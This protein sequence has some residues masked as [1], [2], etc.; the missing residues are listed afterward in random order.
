MD[1]SVLSRWLE[2]V[3]SIFPDYVEITSSPI[4]KA[5]LIQIRWDSAMTADR[6]N[7]VETGV[8][9]LFTREL[10][11]DYSELNA[12]TQATW[13]ARIRKLIADKHGA[14]D[15]DHDALGESPSPVEHWVISPRSML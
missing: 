9:I 15:T 10:Y 13:D 11:E 3:K 4:G 1:S 2:I 14:L 5:V 7:E 12:H 6:A 8:D